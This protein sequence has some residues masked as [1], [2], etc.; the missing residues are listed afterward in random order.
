MGKVSE[1]F[2]SKLEDNDPAY[3]SDQEEEETL[4]NCCGAEFGPP[5]YPDCD[6]CT[7]CGE[8]A[9]PGEEE[10]E[11]SNPDDGSWVGR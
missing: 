6:I 7:A 5:G 4:S 11:L 3:A 1:Y 10:N 8:H 2:R 9:D